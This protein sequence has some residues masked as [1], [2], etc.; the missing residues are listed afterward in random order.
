LNAR[1]VLAAVARALRDD[2]LDP[3]VIG[4]A[5]GRA[6]DQNR[7][8]LRSGL[9]DWWRQLLISLPVRRRPTGPR[10]GLFSMSSKKLS[11]RQKALKTLKV[12]SKRNLD[13]QISR[14]LAKPMNERAHFLRKRVGIC[15]SAI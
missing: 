5:S 4:T 9:P 11:G 14:L 15:R 8:G 7:S 6:R 13:D 3:V 2:E 1:S 10:I 12:E